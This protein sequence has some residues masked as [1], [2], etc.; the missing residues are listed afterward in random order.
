MLLKE[1]MK[2]KVE[3]LPPDATLYEVAK[4]MKK[5]DIDTLPI[6]E[7]GKT[8]GIITDRDLVVRA[9]AEGWDFKKKFARD[10]MSKD[11]V[12]CYDDQTLD[13]AA[14]LFEEKKLYRMPVFNH[15]GKTVGLFSITDLAQHAPFELTG[16]VIRAV[17]QH[18]H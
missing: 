17:S 16:S 5:L 7:N 12:Y 3:A 18:I 9:L 4:T 6:E 11:I 15:S 14:H 2:T 10:L 8:I 13:D 1:I